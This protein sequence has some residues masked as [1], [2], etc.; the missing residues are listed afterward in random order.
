MYFLGSHCRDPGTP[1]GAIKSGKKHNEGDV[2]D[3][4]C[5]YGLKLFQGSQNRTCLKNKT[6]SGTPPRCVGKWKKIKNIEKLIIGN[7]RRI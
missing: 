2:V 7:K 4:T 5:K 1:T 3:Y 6:W